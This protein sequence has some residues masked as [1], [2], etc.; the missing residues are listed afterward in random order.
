[1]VSEKFTGHFIMVFPDFFESLLKLGY[2]FLFSS[3]IFTHFICLLEY[4]GM[5]VW[6]F[7]KC[8][9]IFAIFLHNTQGTKTVH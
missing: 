9:T 5:R 2:T 8:F 4:T 3:F 1:L 6:A 7:E